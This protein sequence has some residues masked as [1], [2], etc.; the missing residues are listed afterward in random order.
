[1]KLHLMAAGLYSV[2][3]VKFLLSRLNTEIQETLPIL[4]VYMKETQ[5]GRLTENGYLIFQINQVKMKFI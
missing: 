3:E 4:Q 1:M 2:Q 5:N